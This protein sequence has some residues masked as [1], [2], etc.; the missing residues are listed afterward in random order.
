MCEMKVIKDPTLNSSALHQETNCQSF[1]LG[2]CKIIFPFPRWTMQTDW[3]PKLMVGR[4][5]NI[6]DTKTNDPFDNQ[7]FLSHNHIDLA[8]VHIFRILSTTKTCRLPSRKDL[9]GL[10]VSRQH[11]GAHKGL[12][13]RSIHASLEN[14]RKISF[15]SSLFAWIFQYWRASHE[16]I[17]ST[18]KHHFYRPRPDENIS[19]EDML[20][21]KY[22][23]IRPAPGYPSQPDHREKKT[24]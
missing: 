16:G 15:T 2:A 3:F 9:V 17:S 6:Q 10:L 13:R 7:V 8:F 20:K 19:L 23:G 4:C 22:Q 24:L 14:Q 5:W 21:V 1:L 11:R 18:T 12:P